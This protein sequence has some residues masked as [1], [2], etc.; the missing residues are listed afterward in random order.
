MD[1]V[2]P[3]LGVRVAQAGRVVQVDREVPVQ[4]RAD[5]DD[6]KRGLVMG[7]VGAEYF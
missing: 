4:V 2:V 5:Q 7:A 3:D 1:R 6:L